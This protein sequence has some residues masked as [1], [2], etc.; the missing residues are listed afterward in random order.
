MDITMATVQALAWS[1]VLCVSVS[2]LGI[3]LETG[4]SVLRQ[5]IGEDPVLSRAADLADRAVL[6]ASARGHGKYN[7]LLGELPYGTV[8]LFYAAVQHEGSI[9]QHHK[10]LLVAAVKRLEELQTPKRPVPEGE[11]FSLVSRVETLA[12]LWRFAASKEGQ[13]RNET[14]FLELFGTATGALK[15]DMSLN[16]NAEFQAHWNGIM[17]L[18]VAH[19]SGRFPLADRKEALRQLNDLLYDQV[20][21]STPPSEAD[22]NLWTEI[23]NQHQQAVDQALEIARLQGLLWP[24]SPGNTGRASQE[25]LR[26]AQCLSR[27]PLRQSFLEQLDAAAR[28]AGGDVAAGLQVLDKFYNLLAGELPAGGKINRMKFEGSCALGLIRRQHELFMRFKAIDANTHAWGERQ[29]RA[30]TELLKGP[31]ADSRMAT[32]MEMWK[33]RYG[34][35]SARYLAVLLDW[36]Q[37]VTS[38]PCPET[39]LGMGGLSASPLFHWWPFLREGTDPLLL[40]QPCF[41]LLER[42]AQLD[43]ACNQAVSP[44]VLL[45]ESL[46]P[47]G[48]RTISNL[49]ALAKGLQELGKEASLGR[50]QGSAP[51]AALGLVPS[52]TPEHQTHIIGNLLF[53]G[54]VQV[55]PSWR[56]TD[57]VRLVQAALEMRTPSSSV[58][59]EVTTQ[60]A[61]NLIWW[62]LKVNPRSGSAWLDGAFGQE[63]SDW[64]VDSEPCA[65]IPWAEF[66]EVLSCVEVM[67]IVR[68]AAFNQRYFQIKNDSG[69][70]DGISP[71][72][73][74][75]VV[76]GLARDPRV[77]FF[78]GMGEGELANLTLLGQILP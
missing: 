67:Q 29:I 61:L 13:G 10:P 46:A 35:E 8:F 16:L 55:P 77:A 52:L 12:N 43:I 75:N 7:G 54:P 17:S 31:Y 30:L 32:V 50:R 36:Y 2:A 47:G 59:E 21:Q 69:P 63:I 66:W 5:I 65:G 70:E 56:V 3:S 24:D 71:Q 41:D 20:G 19:A 53:L 14:E 23:C 73:I 34:G 9:P 28:I 38:D 72:R 26:W 39:F 49:A 58:V 68:E 40:D 48:L 25:F 44:A 6:C 64:L 76:R 15:M 57:R 18:V 78:L 62:Y 1:G 42:A 4:P 37:R 74:G 33:L 11:I 60:Q 51:L 27:I 45:G 22:W